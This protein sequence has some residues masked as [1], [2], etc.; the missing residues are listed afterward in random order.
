MLEKEGDVA[1]VLAEPVRC[2]TVNPPPEGYWQLVREAC[3]RHGVLLVFDETAVC[4]GRTGTMYAFE[5]FGVVPDIV[6]LGKG[7]GGGVFPLAAVVARRGLDCAGD[8]ALGHY[9]HE[10]SPVACAA[11]LAAIEYIEEHDLLVR[12]RE[13]GAR[14]LD[15]LNA[16]KRRH[17]LVGDVRGIGLAMG[18]ELVREDGT[19]AEA[20]ADRALYAC[21]RR[22]LSFKVSGGQLPDPD[23]A[24]D[25]QRRRN[26]PRPRRTRRVP[27]RS[28]GGSRHQPQRG[29][30][31][32]HEHS[33]RQPVCFVD[34]RPAVHLQ[35]GE[36]RHAPG[37]VYLGRRL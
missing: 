12:A 18:L 21:L 37:L 23:P 1:C 32:G 24:A 25:R 17:P 6:T 11:G 22:G 29:L 33:S 2:T 13:L 34:P 27:R 16:L 9:T 35:R 4:L 7:L 8:V 36:G 19:P 10:K 30:I 14:T 15:S 5:N 3:D 26:A 28:R 20:E 31:H